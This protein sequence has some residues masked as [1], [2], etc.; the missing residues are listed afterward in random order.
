M[1]LP[2]WNKL[3]LSPR[4]I[5]LRQAYCFT[6]YDKTLYHMTYSI[7]HT[8]FDTYQAPRQN[9]LQAGHFSKNAFLSFI[10]RGSITGFSLFLDI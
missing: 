8:F 7:N 9:N 3:Y 2:A 4:G 6:V 5:G 10:L 1:P